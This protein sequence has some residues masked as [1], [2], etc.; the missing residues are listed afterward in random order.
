[1]IETFVWWLHKKV[2]LDEDFGRRWGVHFTLALLLLTT[3]LV[4]V[5]AEST[6]YTTFA[7]IALAACFL[8]GAYTLFAI[9]THFVRSRRHR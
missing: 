9:A 6:G 4:I 3:T 8:C 1:M 2:K 7:W 5:Y